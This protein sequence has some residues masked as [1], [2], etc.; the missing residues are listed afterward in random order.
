MSNFKIKNA[1]IMIS[2]RI[3]SN[4]TKNNK[5][6]IIDQNS[7]LIKTNNTKRELNIINKSNIIDK[8]L[9]ESNS[10][11]YQKIK[12]QIEN[13][14]HKSNRKL[15]L[16]NKSSDMNSNIRNKKIVLEKN[17]NFFSY[18]LTKEKHTYQNMKDNYMK[19]KENLFLK[20]NS[21][22]NSSF[23]HKNVIDAK[24]NKEECKIKN[25]K[26]INSSTKILFKNNN[27]NNKRYFNKLNKENNNEKNN[28]DKINLSGKIGKLPIKSLELDSEN[29]SD[30]K[31][32]N[33]KTDRFN[34]IFN[35]YIW[36][37]II[38]GLNSFNKIKNLIKLN[39]FNLENYDFNTIYK[40]N[41]K[42]NT[43]IN[44]NDANLIN[45]SNKIINNNNFERNENKNITSN[46]NNNSFDNNKNIIKKQKIYLSPVIT[47]IKQD[48]IIN[49][50]KDKSNEKNKK[51]YIFDKEYKKY[52]INE[53]NKYYKNNSFISIKDFYKEWLIENQKFI[54][55]NDIHFYLNEIIKLNKPIKKE[56]IF[57]FFFN[58]FQI[59]GLD[60]TNFKK[61]FF[62]NESEKLSDTGLKIEIRKEKKLTKNHKINLVKENKENIY[63][64][65]LKKIKEFLIKKIKNNFNN[66][67]INYNLSYDNFYNLIKNNVIIE[68]QYYYYFFNDMIK[69]I[70][71]EYYDIEKNKINLL[72]IVEK[73]N[74]PNKIEIDIDN[75]VNIKEI[76]EDK[77]I[78]LNYDFKMK[79]IEKEKEKRSLSYNNINDI[80]KK[81]YIKKIYKKNKKY[82]NQNNYNKIKQK[83]QENK[84]NEKATKSEYLSSSR[85]KSKNS[86]IINYL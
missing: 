57:N 60:Y 26:K 25:Y 82:V 18:R 1:E 61:L 22:I 68:K 65:I 13:F 8:I 63:L 55:I 54:T 49:L 3:P 47:K 37:N 39:G 69:K 83:N 52:I 58:D 64:I 71:L 15:C 16:R 73:R 21:Y 19:Y 5:P 6:L 36:N 17:P 72:Y 20:D 43:N 50:K 51:I 81:N 80:N 29:L 4:Y 34:K 31:K 53:V 23:L 11:L 48:K 44:F 24:I 2:R 77:K 10:K 41:K 62:V 32:N 42:N 45:V 46:I 28:N 30:S 33:I 40:D 7:Y 12:T 70:Y 84:V 27:T 78:N 86:D 67:R 14:R 76:K 66:K 56:T 74:K 85:K 9:N 38:N 79:E 35:K 59:N 75:S